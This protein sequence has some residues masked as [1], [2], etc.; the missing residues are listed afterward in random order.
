LFFRKTDDSLIKDVIAGIDKFT[1]KIGEKPEISIVVSDD[2][3]IDTKTMTIAHTKLSI[4]D[5]Y[6]D[7]LKAVDQTIIKRLSNK[8]D[9]G[10]VLLYGKAGTGKTSYIRHLIA[11][12]KKKFIFLPPH[13]AK[14]I[15]S[16]QLINILTEHPNS[17]FV[18][19][20]AENIIID[21][22]KSENSPVTALLNISDGLLSDCLNVQIIC[23]FNTNISNIDNALMRKGRLIAKYEF[24]E[25]DTCKAQALSNKLGFTS[26]ID[27]SMTLAEI[28]HQNEDDYQ[29]VKKRNTIGFTSSKAI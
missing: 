25:L 10:V 29:Q 11:R 28:Y 14:E 2:D 26:K 6:N 3:G 1:K 9:K 23:T 15:S 20:D 19:E 5:N 18:I 4:D 21:R 17:I 16:P 8:N 22:D 12:V 13:L 27:K 7:D 24:A